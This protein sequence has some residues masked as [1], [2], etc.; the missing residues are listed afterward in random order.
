MII[1]SAQEAQGEAIAFSANGNGY[2]SISEQ[3]NP[4]SPVHVYFTKKN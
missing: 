4:T 3:V 2:Y 1:P